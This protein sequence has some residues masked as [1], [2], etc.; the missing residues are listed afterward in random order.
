VRV[1]LEDGPALV[2]VGV[3]AWSL[4]SAL[5]LVF[6][7]EQSTSHEPRRLMPLGDW[8]GLVRRAPD[9]R[10]LHQIRLGDVWQDVCELT[11]EEMPPIDRVVANWY[12]STHPHSHFRDRL[13]VA[14]AAPTGRVTLVDAELTH[15]ARDGSSRVRQ[16]RS[17]EE[18]LQVLAEEFGVELPAGTRFDTP[19]LSALPLRA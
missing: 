17:S 13:M 12:T 6:E 3:G 11:L 8:E 18:L 2:D 5:R 14:R 7:T 10:L 16:L 15:R 4:T 9:A 19:G 1:D